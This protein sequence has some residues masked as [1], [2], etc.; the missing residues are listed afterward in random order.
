MPALAIASESGDHRLRKFDSQTLLSVRCQLRIYLEERRKMSDTPT[1][2]KSSSAAVIDELRALKKTNI[3]IWEDHQA[4]F[5]KI[6]VT[7]SFFGILCFLMLLI[8]ACK[9]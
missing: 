9:P 6:F 2:S 4:S 1:K 5:R 7:I 3:E 8:I